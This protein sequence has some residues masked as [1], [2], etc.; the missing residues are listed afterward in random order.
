MHLVL[1]FLTVLVIFT[2]PSS[3][4]AQQDAGPSGIVN[5]KPT[6]LDAG[7]V[8]VGES[9]IPPTSPLYFLKSLRERLEMA[10]TFSSEGKVIRQLEFAQRRLREVRS[11]VK[12]KHQEE[13]DETLVSYQ[14]HIEQAE[15]FAKDNEDLKIKVGEAVSRHSDVLQKVYDSVGNME[16]KEALLENITRAQVQTE[17]ILQSVNETRQKILND[18]VSLRLTISCNFLGRE[19]TSS[20]VSEEKKVLLKAKFVE[21]SSS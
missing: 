15:N 20:A 14:K 9:L 18:N 21:C 1:F 5:L 17:T 6:V 2:L 7:A 4:L 19:S 11:L 8:D 16:A 3:V 10:L 13:I 12:N